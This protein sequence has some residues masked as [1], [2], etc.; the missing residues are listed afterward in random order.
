MHL[1]LF[2]LDLVFSLAETKKIKRSIL[3]QSWK[4]KK[5][6]LAR[7]P[8]MKRSSLL[9]GSLEKEEEEASCSENPENQAFCLVRSMKHK[10]HRCFGNKNIKPSV[11]FMIDEKHK[12]ISVL[13]DNHVYMLLK[14]L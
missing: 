10:N 12:K 6:I 5:K 9:F 3:A 8:K 2:F 11:W 7:K 1:V 14:D 13:A 4:K